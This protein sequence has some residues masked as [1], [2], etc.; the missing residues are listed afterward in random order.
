MDDGQAN[1]KKKTNKIETMLKV[2]QNTQ[3]HS[4]DVKYI[5]VYKTVP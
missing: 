1:E 2:R 4:D 3:T 5:Y